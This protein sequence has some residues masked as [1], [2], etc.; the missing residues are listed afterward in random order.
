[1]DPF[2]QYNSETQETNYSQIFS[3]LNKVPQ[4]LIQSTRNELI[5]SAA[6]QLIAHSI[7][8]PEIELQTRAAVPHWREIIE[9]ALKSPTVAVQESAANAMTAVSKLTD[10][11]MQM[12]R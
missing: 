2:I 11:N 10:C 5:T 8:L 9:F 12:E 6:C 4:K 3:L 7:S 1:M